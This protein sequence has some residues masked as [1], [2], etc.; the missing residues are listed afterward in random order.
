MKILSLL[1]LCVFVI[2]ATYVVIGV[3]TVIKNGTSISNTP[4]TIARLKSFFTTNIAYTSPESP[5]PEL[6]PRNYPLSPEKDI[7]H[8]KDK[9][10]AS[11]E[12]LGYK[13]NSEK[14]PDNSLHF[15]IT[16][17]TFK[18]VDDL[19]IELQE[20]N[21]LLT[22]NA[23]SSSRTGRADFGANIA[24]IRNFFDAL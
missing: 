13:F 9:V 21:D 11:A 12:Q 23:R 7:N 4:G 6:K 20:D 2:V 19:H 24:N 10:I 18:F 22:I 8:Y 14:S 15:T 1:V 3:G 5:Y 17:K 16:T